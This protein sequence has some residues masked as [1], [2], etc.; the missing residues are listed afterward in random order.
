[1]SWQDKFPRSTQGNASFG[2]A[3]FFVRTGERTAGRRTVTHEYPLRDDPFV[4]DLGRGVRKFEVEGYVIGPEYL[5]ARDALITALETEGAQELVHPLYGTK[6]V[7][8]DGQVKIRETNDS[9]GMA[10]FT[11]PFIET[12]AKPVQ[13]SAALDGSGLVT[14][15]AAAAGAAAGTS[16]LSAYSPGLLLASISQSVQ[17]ALGK[18]N[19]VVAATTSDAQQLA[20]IQ[21]QV[22][23]LK[24]AAASLVNEPASLL[25]GLQ[26]V[27]D[28]VTSVSGLVSLYVYDPGVVPPATTPD[29]I[30]E[31]AN[32]F[33]A[34][35]LI[36]RLALVQAATLLPSQTFVSY[37]D[38]V[39]QR[40]AITE[41]IDDQALVAADDTYPALVQL[42]A[43]LCMAVPGANSD[44]PRIAS[45]TPIT[46]V[47]SLV[48][49]QQL[50]GDVSLEQDIID[51]NGVQNPGF[52]MGGV[53]LE[54]LSVS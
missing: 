14:A 18:V 15:S 52:I 33:A 1:M 9:G 43:D 48:L 50:Y 7:T 49:A 17:N 27:F 5:A 46:T 53:A 30:I 54:V 22:S 13:P 19:A 8:L 34:Q 31:Q 3:K 20:I 24:S 29:R 6:R 12:P 35:Q 32:F 23:N 42:R 25:S 40:T 39:T 10:V 36:Q 21:S 28:A 51:R 26:G 44:L 45:H 41:L 11:M 47:P 16:F 38:A 37:E 4:E 2:G